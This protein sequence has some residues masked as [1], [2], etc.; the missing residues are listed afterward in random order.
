MALNR[1]KNKNGFALIT[2]LM[3]TLISLTIVMAL[4]YMMT[5]S[6][7]VSGMNK[8]YK[9]ALE[10]T[11]GG[12]EIYAKDILPFIMRN[13]SSATMTADLQTAFSNGVT[14]TKV[15]SAQSCLQSKLTKSTANWPAGCSNTPNPKQSPDMSFAMSA[16][17]GSPFV[18]YSKIVDT[19]KGNSD[20][21]G[22]QLEGSGVAESSTVLTP[23]SFPYIY[24][25]E[26]QGERQN[27]PTAQ[28]NIEVLYAY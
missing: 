9:T 19:V 13:Y 22:L 1:I 17:S 8:H 21:S 14:V 3:L 18:V 7:Q 6:V 26:L 15:L 28:A 10:A 12:A 20:T 5:Q 2:S 23:Q 11:Y 16:V 25:M 27:N 4:L 24:R